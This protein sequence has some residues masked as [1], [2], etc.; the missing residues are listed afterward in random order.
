MFEKYKDIHS[1][2][3]RDEIYKGQLLLPNTFGGLQRKISG[4]IK[5]T[6][7]FRIQERLL[8]FTSPTF[9]YDL[10]L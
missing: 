2:C 7:K 5:I 6:G 9:Y 8:S 3:S 10:L 4:T 1:L